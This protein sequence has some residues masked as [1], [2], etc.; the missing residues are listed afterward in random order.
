MPRIVRSV[1]GKDLPQDMLLAFLHRQA[2]C[3]EGLSFASADMA[4]HGHGNTWTD[5]GRCGDA[6]ICMMLC[7]PMLDKWDVYAFSLVTELLLCILQ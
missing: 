4:M 5:M 3:P 7:R 1:E 6:D 2:T